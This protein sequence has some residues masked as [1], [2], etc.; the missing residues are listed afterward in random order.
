KEKEKEKEKE[1]KKKEE[2]EKEQEKSY[3][4]NEQGDEGC[5]DI[6]RETT[7][8]CIPGTNGGTH[9]EDKDDCNPPSTRVPDGGSTVMLLGAALIALGT[10]PKRKS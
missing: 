4:Q 5:I 3:K 6:P 7:G 2:K 1:K 9:E 10:L 8:D